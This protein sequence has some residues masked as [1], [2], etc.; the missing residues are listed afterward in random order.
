MAVNTLNKQSRTNDKGW[1]SSMGV[2]SGVKPFTVKK[3]TNSL[4]EFWTWILWKNDL[5]NVNM[6]MR[7]GTWNVRNFCRQVH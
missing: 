2:G 5:M 1:S 3:I 4:Q 7:F 6:I